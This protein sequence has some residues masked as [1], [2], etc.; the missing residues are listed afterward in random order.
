MMAKAGEWNVGKSPEDEKQL[1]A[2]IQLALESLE[3][4]PSE[5]EP[6][7]DSLR[8]SAAI[9]GLR[10]NLGRNNEKIAKGSE[11]K[12]FAGAVDLSGPRAGNSKV[13]WLAKKGNSKYIACWRSLRAM[14]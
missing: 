13:S 3:P 1:L 4:E 9:R 11:P 12:R 7:M 5:S 2:Q 6:G 10:L 14:T 8:A